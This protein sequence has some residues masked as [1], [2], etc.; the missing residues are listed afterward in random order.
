M[1]RMVKILFMHL[2]TY[3]A[4]SVKISYIYLLIFVILFSIHNYTYAFQNEWEPY[5][6]EVGIKLFRRPVK[7][8][9]LYE[10]KAVTII[11]TSIEAIGL[12]LIDL[13][14]YPKWMAG[15]KKTEIIEQIDEN[16]LLTY[17]IQKIIWPLKDRYAVLKSIIEIDWK[18]G[19]FTV[20]FV[21]IDN[22]HV[23]I[24][25]N[26]IRMAMMKGRWVIQAIGDKQA[27]VIYTIMVDPGGTLPA[28]LVNTEMKSIHF[29]TMRGLK[30]ITAEKKYIE[31]ASFFKHY[32]KNKI[33]FK[34]FL[35]RS[36]QNNIE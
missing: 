8:S 30:R 5:K 10:L 11:N 26:L 20:E 24:Q 1:L 7:D 36:R 23:R 4:V 12:V 21:A 35:I 22:S 3:G 6:E 13:P 18:S 16:T 17:Y 15:C 32:E 29:N 33:N 28:I 34:E 27:R 9:S 25:E 2:Y 14:S 19:L 31:A